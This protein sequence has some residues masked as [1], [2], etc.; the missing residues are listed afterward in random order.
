M[1][2]RLP[3]IVIATAAVVAA[4]CRPGGS[5][6]PVARNVL[7]VTLDTTRADRLSCYGYA[8]PTTP[9]MDAVAADGVR[10]EMAIAQAALTPVSHASILTGLLPPHHGLRVL[11]A[12]SGYR[13]PEEI[14]TLATELRERGWSTAAFLSSFTVSGFFGF[15]RGFETFDDGL[16]HPP[17]GVLQRVAEGD[18]RFDVRANQRRSDRTTDR[19]VEWLREIRQPFFLWVHYWDPHDPDVVPPAEVVSKFA[20]PPGSSNA[21]VLRALYDAEV[22]FVD[23]Q[24]AHL[25]QTLEELDVYDDTAIVVVADHG[26]GLGD[27]GH[28][29]HRILYQEQIRVPLFMRFPEGPRGRVVSDL[30]NTTDIYPTVLDWLDLELPTPV[31]GRSLFGLIEGRDETPRVAYAE[32]LILYDLNARE[33]LSWRPDDGLLYSLIDRNWKLLYKPLRPDRSELYDL[34]ADPREL[35]NL[36]ATEHEQ[37]KR[38]FTEL[39]RFDAFVDR[40]FGEGTDEEVLERLRSLGYVGDSGH[41]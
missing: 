40:P 6:E 13:L 28:W 35:H 29:F 30:V 25:R 5:P 4:G 2:S 19:A 14:P 41:E 10:F 31:D 23:L 32:A 21:D 15:E 8:Q 26:Q 3:V 7:L 27:H 20:P 34:E 11:Y 1:F 17:D 36:F 33:L 37:G 12:E 24:F 38:M 18:Y 9:A 22:H 39:E 16:A